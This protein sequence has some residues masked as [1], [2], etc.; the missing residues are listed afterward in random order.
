MVL[1]FPR[2]LPLGST[3]G[4]FPR[5]VGKGPQRLCLRPPRVSVSS[6]CRVGSPTPGSELKWEPVGKMMGDCLATPP[7]RALG[8]DRRVKVYHSVARGPGHTGGQSLA[9]TGGAGGPLL[10]G[11]PCETWQGG[12]CRGNSTE[13]GCLRLGVGSVPCAV[14][15]GQPHPRL[16]VLAHSL[17]AD[18]TKVGPAAPT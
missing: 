11:R 16:M 1:L 6:G 10:L 12:P 14:P 8:T 2:F 15:V 13:S 18:N 9:L 5:G 4:A 3:Y 7:A 17:K